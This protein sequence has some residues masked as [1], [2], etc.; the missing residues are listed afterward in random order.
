MKKQLQPYQDRPY[1]Q[2]VGLLLVNHDRLVFVGRR[3]DQS[4][5]AWQMPQGGI[6]D[7]EDARTAAIRELGEEIGTTRADIVAE[8]R[9][10]IPYDLPPAIAD[11]VWKGKFRGQMQKWFLLRFRGRD[12]DI[13][14]DTHHPEFDRWRWV[15]PSDVP[16]LIVPFKQA[17]Y[18]RVMD[19]FAPLIATLR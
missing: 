2:G 5:E 19:E 9:D 17:L 12:S 4:A 14:L 3:I 13:R 15:A 8:S 1:R 6:D 18:A 7:G 10:W 11:K 16:A